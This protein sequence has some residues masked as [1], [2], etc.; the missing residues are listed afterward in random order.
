M[1]NRLDDEKECAVCVEPFNQ[2]T[3]KKVSCVYCNYQVC[4]TCLKTYLEN[5]LDCMN[6]KNEWNRS[7]LNEN[8]TSTWYKKNYR[9]ILKERYLDREKTMLQSAIPKAKEVEITRLYEKLVSEKKREIEQLAL[10]IKNLNIECEAKCGMILGNNSSSFNEIEK[11]KFLKACPVENCR[12]FLST[13]WKCELCDIKICKDCYEIK[14]DNHECNPETLE[15]AKLIMKDSKP[16]PK[17]GF[18]ICHLGGCKHMFCVSCKTCFDWETGKIQSKNSNPHYYEWMR[19]QGKT[20]EREQGDTPG[21]PRGNHCRFNIHAYQ[22]IDQFNVNIH[23]SELKNVIDIHKIQ[24]IYRFTEHISEIVLPSFMNDITYNNKLMD[25]RVKFLTKDIDEE[26]WKNELVKLSFHYECQREQYQLYDIVHNVIRD[27]VIKMFQG[28]KDLQR[29]LSEFEE[30]YIQ[31]LSII[32]YF[33]NEMKNLKRRFNSSTY[34]EIT[35]NKN[36]NIKNNNYLSNN[37]R[38]H[39]YRR[40]TSILIKES[41][42]NYI[43]LK[44]KKINEKKD[45]DEK[46]EKKKEKI[47]KKEIDYEL[48]SSESESG[49]YEYESD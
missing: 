49:E 33:N 44:A 26:K 48:S 12:G 8:M 15:T 5:R 11:P 31:I 30:S 19:T 16:C 13:Q 45:P 47:I 20:L 41:I 24:D 40:G 4:K 17:C 46:K 32:D 43:L 29:N 39:Y 36:Y 21:N 9:D 10:D 3:R 38:P 1:S 27:S 37:R 34:H 14:N 6:C 28:P 35:F 18:R 23:K 25:L 42:S 2:S 7:F 22:G